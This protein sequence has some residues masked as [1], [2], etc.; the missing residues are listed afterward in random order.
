MEYVNLGSTGLRVSR[1]CL[2]MMSFGRHESREWALTNRRPSPHL[3]RR[4]R[5]RR[6]SRASTA[7]SGISG[8]GHL[9]R[10]LGE[11]VPAAGD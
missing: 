9:A 1:L 10:A 8:R 11:Q 6:R 7:S 3:R 5:D 2:G 4:W